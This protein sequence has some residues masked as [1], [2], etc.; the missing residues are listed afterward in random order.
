MESDLAKGSFLLFELP[1]TA[2]SLLREFAASW[3]GHQFQ[4][5][6]KQGF[7]K[8]MATVTTMQGTA[9]VQ[10][11]RGAFAPAEQLLGVTAGEG[12]SVSLGCCHW[13][14]WETGC[15]CR[16]EG[17]SGDLNPGPSSP[18]LA[19]Q[20]AQLPVYPLPFSALIPS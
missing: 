7:N 3:R 11:E 10:Y 8:S 2:Q 15:W 20:S 1:Q 18:R 17:L 5:L 13:P 6:S 19:L 12:A 16:W 14:W 9:Y 4:L